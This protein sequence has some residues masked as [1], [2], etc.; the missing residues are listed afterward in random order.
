MDRHVR[1]LGSDLESGQFHGGQGCLQHISHAMSCHAEHADIVRNAEAVFLQSAEGT[2]P[3]RIGRGKDRV[4]MHVPV[5]QLVRAVI[6]VAD[7]LEL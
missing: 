1:C 3:L 7:P 6:A 2:D 4:E 5:E